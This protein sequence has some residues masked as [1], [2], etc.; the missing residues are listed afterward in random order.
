MMCSNISSKFILGCYKRVA[1][2]LG[3]GVQ[4]VGEDPAVTS[5]ADVGEQVGSAGAVEVGVIRRVAW[6]VLQARWGRVVQPLGQGD[7]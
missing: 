1:H 4:R 7:R 3:N 6:F 2:G 5:L